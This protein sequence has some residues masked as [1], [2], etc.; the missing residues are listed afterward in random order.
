MDIKILRK[1]DVSKLIDSIKERYK[2]DIEKKGESA[3]EFL[4]S[5][6]EKKKIE[7]KDIE[8]EFEG[9]FDNIKKLKS[10]R[11]DI[12]KKHNLSP[13][14]LVFN[15]DTLME[16]L[17]KKPKNLEELSKIN[18]IGATKIKDFGNEIIN[19]VKLNLIK[20]IK[21]TN[22]ENIIIEKKKKD[23]TQ[24]EKVFL[25]FL[26]KERIK[27]ADFNKMK[28]EDVFSESVAYNLV[29]MKPKNLKTLAMV[30][31]FKKENIDKFGSYLVNKIDIFL[32]K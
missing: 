9:D 13:V 16:I 1:E 17:T 19:F 29:K 24:E 30:F 5:K 31:G 6:S 4:D 22:K 3:I 27:I 14:Y 28:E 2:L 26:M 10:L 7:I 21:Q 18:G 15:N 32:K 8:K 25:D 12:S 11:F 20:D 23:L